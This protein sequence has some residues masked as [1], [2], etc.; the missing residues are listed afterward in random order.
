MDNK[1][2]VVIRGTVA[3]KVALEAAFL[4]SADKEAAV[5]MKDSETSAAVIKDLEVIK[6][7]DLVDSKAFPASVVADNKDMVTKDLVAE[8][9]V[10]ED[11]V[12]KVDLVEVFP[13]SVDKAV[14]ADL[15]VDYQD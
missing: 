10:S 1:D 4:A 9:L 2:T 8:S 6:A 12:V 13:V 7:A 5:R 3:N 15:V 11:K 14:K